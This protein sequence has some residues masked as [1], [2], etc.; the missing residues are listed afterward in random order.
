MD[1]NIFSNKKAELAKRLS[2]GSSAIYCLMERY[3]PAPFR[4]VQGLSKEQLTKKLLES[5]F[6]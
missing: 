5:S 4:K 6:K 2:F 1:K 3:F